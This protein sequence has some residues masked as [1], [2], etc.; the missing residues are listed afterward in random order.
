MTVLRTGWHWL[1][2][3]VRGGL[4][5]VDVLVDYLYDRADLWQNKE[6]RTADH[7]KVRSFLLYAIVAGVYLKLAL[8]MTFGSDT[9]KPFPATY[10]MYM[11]WALLALSAGERVLLAFFKMMTPRISPSLSSDPP[12][13]GATQ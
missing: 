3:A 2:A 11:G 9:E 13:N 4:S 12:T 6:H 5:V 7:A 10:L 1:R 8:G